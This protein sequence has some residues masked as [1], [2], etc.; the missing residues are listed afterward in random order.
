MK[1]IGYFLKSLLFPVAVL[2]TLFAFNTIT[3]DSDAGIGVMI[4][5]MITIPPQ[6][7][8]LFEID[9][10]IGLFALDF[11]SCIVGA[12]IG[13]IIYIC[14]AAFINTHLPLVIGLYLVFVAIIRGI[15]AF[16]FQDECTMF[17]NIVAYISAG[18]IAIIG[19]VMMFGGNTEMFIMDFGVL[20]LFFVLIT[21]VYTI[22]AHTIHAGDVLD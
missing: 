11:G 5:L 12:L 21:W 8:L 2:L 4:I 9:E 6:A 1:I 16:R 19:F 13:Y 3:P 18:C 14:A 22:L 17:T 20:F 7:T 15:D 10:G